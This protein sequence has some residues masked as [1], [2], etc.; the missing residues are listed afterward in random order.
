MSNKE[1]VQR[2]EER[3]KIAESGGGEERIKKQHDA[4]RLTARERVALLLD[5]GT[6]VEL[7]SS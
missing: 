6:F 5:A 1:K 4:G 3:H 7:E 2:L